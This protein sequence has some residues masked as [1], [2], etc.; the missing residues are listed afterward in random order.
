MRSEYLALPDNPTTS[1]S[2]H[3][4][5]ILASVAQAMADPSY[6]LDTAEA[7]AML[8]AFAQARRQGYQ[9]DPFTVAL[10][11]VL[12]RQLRDTDDG[13]E[14]SVDVADFEKDDPDDDANGGGWSG[15][16]IA[17]TKARVA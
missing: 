9:A 3:A 7:A 15:V 17:P 13:H 6:E 1:K 10:V 8:L 16:D 12:A 14:D 2:H 5:L 4:A 11:E